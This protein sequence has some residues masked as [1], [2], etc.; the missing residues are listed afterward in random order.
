MTIM[1]VAVN[2]PNQPHN[3]PDVNDSEGTSG[4]KPRFC[5]VSEA[6]AQSSRATSRSLVRRAHLISN[7]GARRVVVAIPARDEADKVGGC[8][9]ALGRQTRLPDAVVLL[10]NNCTDM[11]E[12]VARSIEVP[13]PVEICSTWLSPCD[14]NAGTARR[15]AMNRAS[16]VAGQRGVVMTTDADS[17]APPDWVALNIQALTSGADVVCGQAEIDPQDA[18]LIPAHLH[19]DDVLEREYADLLDAIVDRLCPDPADPRPRHTE[20]SGASLAMTAEVYMQAGGV[21][22]VPN[23]ED[24]ALISALRQIDT[25]IRHDPAVRVAVSGRFVG[26]AEGGMADTI[27]RRLVHQDVF[28]DD[29]LEPPGDAFRRADFRRRLRTAWT[30]GCADADLAVDLRLTPAVLDEHL[31]GRFFGQMWEKIERLSPTLLRR[32]VRFADLHQHIKY[33][34]ELL[35]LVTQVVFESGRLRGCSRTERCGH[36]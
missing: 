13:F 23:G 22:H 1:A 2:R 20:A 26:R 35:L 9:V 12:Q 4:I 21:P 18:A 33:A 8:L 16:L 6:W 25:R 7:E 32:R 36:R 15:L 19:A 5:A 11:T 10:L 27:R 29:S 17:I 30:N 14:A 28:T 24:R 34:R 31:R 3:Q